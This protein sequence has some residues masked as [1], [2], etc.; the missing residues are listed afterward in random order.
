MSDIKYAY[1]FNNVSDNKSYNLLILTVLV[2][3][4]C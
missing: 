4:G 2:C 3:L 1:S